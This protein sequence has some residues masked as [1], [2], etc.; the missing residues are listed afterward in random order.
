MVANG[1]EG[2]PWMVGGGAKHSANVGRLLA[3]AATG[4]GSG[5]VAS[6]DLKIVPSSTPNNQVHMGV[7]ACTMLNRYANAQSESYMAKATDVSD[8]TIPSTGTSPRS[9]LVIVRIKDPQYGAQAPAD[10]AAGP[11]AFPEI[12]SGV[13]ANTSRFE[14]LGLP[15]PAYAVARL[16]IPANTTAIS[17]SHIKDLRKLVQQRTTIV[18][19]LQMVPGTQIL[20]ISRTSWDNWPT[21]SLAVE[22]PDWATHAQ[23]SID[24]NSPMGFGPGSGNGNGSADMH[25][26]AVLGTKVAANATMWGHNAFVGQDVND[27]LDHAASIY[28]EFD[29][30]DVRG[31]TVTVKPQAIRVGTNLTSGR[32]TLY[33]NHSVRFDVRF[34][35]KAV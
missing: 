8:I 35:E 34:V 25:L 4:G 12:I 29:V 10:V 32:I 1:F 23:V 3:Y 14:Q 7:G 6:G 33:G 19:D 26:R 28:A 22:V 2:V 16:D 20:D 17:T 24:L 5:V 18:G 15:F 30:R 27:G 13:P 9:D 31:Q 11:Y 21:N